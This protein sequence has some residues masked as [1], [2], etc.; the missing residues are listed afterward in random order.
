MSEHL[1]ESSE[2]RA[3]TAEKEG[4]REV[5]SFD[6]RV[7][8]GC[9]PRARLRKPIKQIVSEHMLAMSSSPPFLFHRSCDRA[10]ESRPL[11]DQRHIMRRLRVD[12]GG[13]HAEQAIADHERDWPVARRDGYLHP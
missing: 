4:G 6:Q 8:C 2:L 5:F 11:A 9:V 1:A 12:H 7:F 10:D 3:S 13:I